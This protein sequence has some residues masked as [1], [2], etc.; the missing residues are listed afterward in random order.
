MKSDVLFSSPV[1][2]LHSVLLLGVVWLEIKAFSRSKRIFSTV[3]WKPFKESESFRTESIVYVSLLLSASGV[4]E[5]CLV[6]ST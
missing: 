6:Y 2:L 1:A 4:T 5:S 3:S